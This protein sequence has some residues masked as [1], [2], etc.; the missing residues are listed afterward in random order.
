[1]VRHAI[2]QVINDRLISSVG[3]TEYLRTID[4]GSEAWYAW[5]NEPGTHS[6]AFQSQE[7]RFTARR[8]HSHGNRYWYAYR[9]QHGQ[10]H[11]IYL[12]KSE[13]LTLLRLQEATT[14]L[15]ANGTPP[16]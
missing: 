15:S 7:G 4:V 6:F 1:M 12:G 16:P 9:S 14:I 5:L 8:E 2:P 13:Q 10:L 11:K 3:A